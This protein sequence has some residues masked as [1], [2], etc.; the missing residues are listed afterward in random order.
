MK[1]ATLLSAALLGGWAFPASAEEVQL[2]LLLGP[3][4]PTENTIE[5]TVGVSGFEDSDTSGVS[6]NAL[7]TTNVAFLANGQVDT[8]QDIAFTGGSVAFEDDLNFNINAIIGSVLVDGT[9]LAGTLGT[10]APPAAMSGS[11]G[12]DLS[13][14]DITVDQGVLTAQ[15]TGLLSDVSQTVDF[16][17][18]PTTAALLGSATL[19]FSLDS[20]LGNTG[21]YTATLV[22]PVSF[23]AP[24]DAGGVTVNVSAEGTL[25]AT[26]TFARQFTTPGDLDGDGLVGVV[27]LDLLLAEWG[28][29]GS[30]ADAD[31]SGTVDGDDLA[32]VL[33]HWGDGDPPDVNIPEPGSLALLALGGLALARRRRG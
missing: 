8:F 6:G 21:Y 16:S 26:D 24:F 5:L 15:G 30:V 9:G 1:Q 3:S 11:G 17:A 12:F 20:V 25:I 33:N 18:T 23:N 4:S 32:I 2:D 27:D 19:G 28:A 13:F 29:S 14:H 7:A 22:A 10:P 31:G